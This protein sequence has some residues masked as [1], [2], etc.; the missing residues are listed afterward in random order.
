M[1]LNMQILNEFSK[2]VAG[3]R[4]WIIIYQMIIT[5]RNFVTR[6]R[7]DWFIEQHQSYAENERGA[8]SPK[9]SWAQFISVTS[10]RHD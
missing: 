4:F 9:F 10:A 2:I 7:L 5:F 1:Y 8:M 3:L 6:E